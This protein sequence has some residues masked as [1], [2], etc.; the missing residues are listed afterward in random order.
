MTKAKNKSAIQRRLIPT[1][2][3]LA[4]WSLFSVFPLYWMIA[5]STNTSKD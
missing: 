1:Y 2:I 5:A 4:I 3:F